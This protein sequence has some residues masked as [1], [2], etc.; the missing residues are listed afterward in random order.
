[1]PLRV[2]EQALLEKD[3]DSLGLIWTTGIEIGWGSLYGDPGSEYGKPSRISLPGY[4]FARERYWIETAAPAGRAAG[5]PVLHPLLHTNTSNLSEQRYTSKLTGDELFLADHLVRTAEPPARKVLPQ[6]AYWEMAR[7]AIVRASPPRH[8]PTVLEL[9]DIEWGQPCV[10]TPDTQISIALW[11]DHSERI[12]YEIYSEEK[13]HTIVHCQGRAVFSPQKVPRKL[14]IERLQ[15]TL[16]RA[17][18]EVGRI[19]AV[20]TRMGL[21]H[22]AAY[23]AIT[24]TYRGEGELL[25]RL[26]VPTAAHESWKEYE[27]YRYALTS[28]RP[29]CRPDF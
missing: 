18:P 23:Q 6:V 22:G 3:L 14:D 15:R 21:G 17:E 8:G 16:H 12:Q 13:D 24:E 2:I 29:R 11:A 10:V 7:A 5:A 9:N 26:R 19:Y 27:R 28:S 4:P 1:M 20:S 25:A